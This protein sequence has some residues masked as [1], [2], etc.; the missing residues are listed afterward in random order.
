MK[1]EPKEI[2]R[3]Y[4]FGGDE[5]FFFA[6]VIMFDVMGESH[7]LTM[8]WGAAIVRPGWF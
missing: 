6:N 8:D 5:E 1:A 3:I 4:H 7:V 2:N